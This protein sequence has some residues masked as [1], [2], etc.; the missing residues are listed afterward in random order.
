M[1]L[2]IYAAAALSVMTMGATA[3][4]IEQRQANM[5]ERGQILR[6]LAPIAQGRADFDAATVLDALEKLNANAQ[7]AADVDAFYP[8]GT[9]TGDTKVK[10]SIWSDREG[11]K[12]ANE[13]YL[14]KVAAATRP[15]A[16][17]GG[18]H[19]LTC[20]NFRR[21]A[22]SRSC[23]RRCGVVPCDAF[24][25]ERRG[26]GVVRGRGCEPGRTGVLGGRLRLVPRGAG[27]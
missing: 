11:F 18:L 14:S 21:L 22:G 26:A 15:T 20:Q 12:K 24:A 5:K 19:V 27:C 8:A 16:T 4:P 17:N 3:N 6:V 1:K 2:F 10:E 7:A 23:R 13:D 25:A 9:E